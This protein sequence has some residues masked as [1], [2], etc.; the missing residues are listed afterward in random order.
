MSLVADPAHWIKAFFN[1]PRTYGGV[2][3]LRGCLLR[4]WPKMTQCKR[5]SAFHCV[6]HMPSDRCNRLWPCGA[7]RANLR[8]HPHLSAKSQSRCGPGFMPSGEPCPEARRAIVALFTKYSINARRQLGGRTRCF[9][10]PT[11]W[12]LLAAFAPRCAEGCL[13]NMVAEG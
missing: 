6:T 7:Y 1:G 4:S 8:G 2:G 13:C 10:T 5:S 11:A 9:T 12:R 3:Q